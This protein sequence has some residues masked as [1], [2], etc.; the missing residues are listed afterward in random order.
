FL[1]TP[2]GGR[3]FALLSSQVATQFLVSSFPGALTTGNS[4]T[5]TVTALNAAGASATRYTGTVH[6]S[7]TDIQA[8]LPA[9]YT[10]CPV[11]QGVQSFNAAFNSIGTQSLTV[12][13][14]SSGAT[15]NQTEINVGQPGT[16][17]TLAL[18]VPALVTAGV[19]FTVTVNAEDVTGA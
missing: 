2:S 7:S 17:S 18:N 3:G 14:P 12:T 8:N 6:F 5:F 9:D 13:D 4:G 16:V 11:D 10:F 1:T 15:G 19:S